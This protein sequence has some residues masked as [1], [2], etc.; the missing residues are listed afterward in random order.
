MKKIIRE[1]ITKIFDKIPFAT[2]LSR[3]KFMG[4]FLIGLIASRRV[5]LQ[6]IAQHIESEA[7]VFS[8][9]RRIQSFF[10]DFEMDYEKVCLL[11]LMFL[12][13]GKLHLS[14]DRTEWDFGVY[15]CNI[16]M[17]VAKS[18][19]MGIPLYW[20]L[21]DNHSGNSSSKDRCKLLTSLTEV[22]GV[23]RI[24]LIV[25]DREFIG[26]EWLK[27][28]KSK[29]INFCMRLPKSHFIT[30]KNGASYSINDLLAQHPERYF[31]N[32]MIDGVWCNTM[33]KKL[34]DGDFLF[35]VGSLPAKQLGNAYRHRWCIEVLFQTFKK[36]GFDLEATHLKESYKIRK[37]LVF[38]SLAV[39]ICSKIEQYMDK[40]VKPIKIKKHKFKAN[41]FFRT[42][43]DYIRQNLIKQK[44]EFINTCSG[45]ID[46]FLRWIEL[47]VYHNQHLIKIFG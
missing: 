22:I 39:A 11:L 34:A 27:F 23:E 12:P 6:E 4:D 9:E 40:K 13:K 7:S 42:G 30:L 21:L 47:L 41:S 32:C 44:R 35:L 36:R 5:Q 46:K 29:G 24:G 10:K 1:K 19:S 45:W 20:E 3:K 18:G 25:G 17:V 31:E 33:L 26:L 2:H 28:L 43:L 15:E 14:I 37:L 8:V 38:V 16:L